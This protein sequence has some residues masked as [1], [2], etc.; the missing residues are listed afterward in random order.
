MKKLVLSVVMCTALLAS[1]AIMAQ[2]KKT[3]E[4]AKKECTSTAKKNCTSTDKKD[5]SKKTAEKKSC[6]S[7]T[8]AEA[9]K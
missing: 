4:P 9:K 8:K 1:S 6:C 3:A 2:D 5:G 7:S